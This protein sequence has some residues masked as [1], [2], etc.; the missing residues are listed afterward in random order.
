M[1]PSHH[2]SSS[3]IDPSTIQ[4]PPSPTPFT[5]PNSSAFD[6]DHHHP[7]PSPNLSSSP[8]SS[9]EIHPH[10]SPP[11]SHLGH[12]SLDPP[13]S[14][15]I[16]PS[17]LPTHHPTP[18]SDSHIDPDHIP[19]D[20]LVDNDHHPP[21]NHELVTNP[22]LDLDH[23]SDPNRSGDDGAHL[24]DPAADEPPE[25]A[26]NLSIHSVNGRSL[27]NFD[28][29]DDD[30]DDDDG[31][32]LYSSDDDQPQPNHRPSIH[33]ISHPN[34]SSDLNSDAGPFN[35]IPDLQSPSN[36]HHSIDSSPDS[37]HSSNPDVDDD[38]LNDQLQSNNH[39]S[40]HSAA[41]S[42]H[43][44]DPDL[45]PDDYQ[46]EPGLNDLDLNYL[47]PVRPDSNYDSMIIHPS[48]SG[49]FPF[50][51][52]AEPPIE[53]R[54]TEPAR[55]S[56]HDSGDDLNDSSDVELD[57]IQN[58]FTRSILDSISHYAS[59]SDS[60]DALDLVL[61]VESDSIDPRPTYATSDFDQQF[62]LDLDDDDVVDDALDD[63]LVTN[64]NHLMMDSILDSSDRLDSYSHLNRNSHDSSIHSNHQLL[65]NPSSDLLRP[66]S[67]LVDRPGPANP[68]HL[69]PP[70]NSPSIVY[71]L[72]PDGDPLTPRLSLEPQP[73][74]ST[75]FPLSVLEPITDSDDPDL[76]S[77]TQSDLMH[78]LE[79]SINS[80]TSRPDSNSDENPISLISSNPSR[81]VLHNSNH[82]VC[83]T[84]NASVG[85]RRSESP[86]PNVEFHSSNASPNSPSSSLCRNNSPSTTSTCHSRRPMIC[87]SSQLVLTPADTNFTV[88]FA[89]LHPSQSQTL[90]QPSRS[91]LSRA[92]TLPSSFPSISGFGSEFR[93]RRPFRNRH[94]S[95]PMIASLGGHQPNGLTPLALPDIPE[96]KTKTSV[97]K[98]KSK[99]PSH[100]TRSF[101]STKRPTLPNVRGS[102]FSLVTAP[103]DGLV[104]VPSNGQ[105]VGV[106]PITNVSMM[107][108]YLVQ[109]FLSPNSAITS[110][111]PSTPYS[112]PTHLSPG[113]RHPRL[114]RSSFPL[115][116]SPIAE[117]F[118]NDQTDSRKMRCFEP[119]KW[120]EL[121]SKWFQPKIGTSIG[122]DE[123]RKP[124]RSQSVNRGPQTLSQAEK[125]L[126]FS[127]HYCCF[128]IP[129]YNAGIYSI[130][131][132]FT[133]LGFVFGILS[134]SA[135]SILAI[136]I[137]FSYTAL[138]GVLCLCVGL[139]Q[140]IGFYAVYKE[141]PDLFKKYTIG[142]QSLLALTFLYS[143]VLLIIS[144]TRHSAAV[145]Q[146]L[147][148]FISGDELNDGPSN[149][150]RQL[151]SVWTHAQLGV[152]LFV[153]LLFLL[154]EVY[155]CYMVK[156]WGRDQKLDHMKYQSII[157]AVRQSMATSFNT[158]QQALL[159][160]ND[161]E[162]QSRAGSL[163][164]RGESGRGRSGSITAGASPLLKHGGSRLKN[165]IE[166]TNVETVDGNA[167]PE[168]PSKVK[169]GKAKLTTEQIEIAEEIVS[170]SQHHSDHRMG[171]MT[172]STRS[173]SLQ[174]GSRPNAKATGGEIESTPRDLR[175]SE[176]TS[177]LASGN[178]IEAID[179]SPP[180]PAP[181]SPITS[182]SRGVGSRSQPATAAASVDASS[183]L[184]SSHR[185][186]P[187]DHASPGLE[188]SKSQQSTDDEEYYK[189]KQT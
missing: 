115:T 75:F 90:I 8:S 55:R 39:H 105:R 126:M 133:I 46:S 24:N 139:V 33:S 111:H 93:N 1:D 187:F 185:T 104:L 94:Q 11:I 171:Y 153:W 100:F 86:T 118:E 159:D 77:L 146:C 42:Y 13:I 56:D 10:P 50:E 68:D 89:R 87:N 38:D 58:F 117:L 130:L 20:E 114:D 30:G 36:P 112:R 29:D 150:S 18:S 141:K 129:L 15:P 2:Q 44:S 16:P 168:E 183:H 182:T 23:D 71:S 73:D 32:L 140:A 54:F 177:R 148:Q 6:H 106:A 9:S 110:S 61:D 145:D 188:H 22:D 107:P 25:M 84:P 57:S 96:T 123:G 92:M 17:T 62:E 138:F 70:I 184:S 27:S 178:W 173:N 60:T 142:T 4:L 179:H 116:P 167:H 135:P 66:L 161:W 152:C 52:L 170:V 119:K 120:T 134:F 103:M 180:S 59:N 21:L 97:A 67:T 14:P 169:S 28:D 137:D 88:S 31:D 189:S 51:S 64:D 95:A 172:S 113:P 47:S 12:S 91:R 65:L 41:D 147:A 53:P 151:C 98:P 19:D 63:R 181:T 101:V 155:C 99:T 165:E 166:W 49:P 131:A 144:F 34:L 69:S 82:S 121:F 48:I 78:R 26:D 43:R 108:L 143:L 149:S 164:I 35:N 132:Q 136:V 83:L 76:T 162:S 79:L 7:H 74:D 128:A 37:D 160:D 154:T 163:D 158:N 174:T 109:P 40:L 45:N 85:S 127:D 80:L 176:R 186:N 156:I 125:V 3:I 157:S 122:L 72:S 124:R 102:K 81:N 175:N 5:T